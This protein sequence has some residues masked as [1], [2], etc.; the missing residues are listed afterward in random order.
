MNFSS[1]WR[2]EVVGSVEDFVASGYGIRGAGRFRFRASGT[3]CAANIKCLAT[4]EWRKEGVAP[5]KDFVSGGRG[6]Y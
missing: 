5:V 4:S 6:R 1:A 2:K 3:S